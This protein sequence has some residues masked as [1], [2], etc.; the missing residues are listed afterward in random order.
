MLCVCEP[1]Y[2]EKKYCWTKESETA[3]WHPSIILQRNSIDLE[4]FFFSLRLCKNSKAEIK[5]VYDTY[6]SRTTT[7]AVIVC[8]AVFCFW[9]VCTKRTGHLH[10]CWIIVGFTIHKIC[11]YY[12]LILLIWLYTHTC[13]SSD[14]HTIFIVDKKSARS[15]KRFNWPFRSKS[16][17]KEKEA[18]TTRT[19]TAVK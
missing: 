16:K 6:Q 7:A 15:P 8:C 4:S 17:Y 5:K 11:K 12:N 2:R 13:T 14:L 18:T 9:F 10:F 3:S 19:T 1:Y